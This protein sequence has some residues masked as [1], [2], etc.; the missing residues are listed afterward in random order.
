[1]YIV[2]IAAFVMFWTGWLLV[3]DKR[4]WDLKKR[5]EKYKKEA[6]TLVENG[7][8]FKGLKKFSQT[9]KQESRQ[10]ELSDCLAY[11]KNIVILGRGKTM[12]AQLLLEELADMSDILAPTFLHMAHCIHICENK[13]AEQLFCDVF[14]KDHGKDIAKLFVE[15][16]SLP[17]E[18]LLGTI[19][20]Y[21]NVLLQKR[22]SAQRRR[23]EIVSDIIYFPVVINSMAV[24][25]NFI[26]ISYFL[27][28]RELLMSIF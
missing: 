18:K 10:R 6:Q 28:Q 16:E 12:S 7:E 20:A 2:Q 27:E 8:I 21:R 4:D 14:E 1:M 26:Y 15:W 13:R 11:I 17:A 3:F 19:T 24:L 9:R 25:L 5:A 23:D 22:Q